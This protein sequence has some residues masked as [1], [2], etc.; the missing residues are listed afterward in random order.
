VAFVYLDAPFR[1]VGIVEV[2]AFA[3]EWSIEKAP[4][5]ASN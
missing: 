1:S 5:R 2:R 3:V 4:T